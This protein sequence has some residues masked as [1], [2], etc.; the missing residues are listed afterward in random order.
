MNKQLERYSVIS[1]KNPR[2]ILLLR[3]KGCSWRNCRFCDYHLDYSLDQEA[4]AQLNKEVLSQVTG[5]FGVL[6]IINS[7][8]FVDLD[9]RTME[10]IKET[11][12]AKHISQIHF[13]SHWLHRQDIQA[14]R[15]FFQKDA[16]AV[17]MKIGVETFDRDFRETVMVKGIDT[18]RPEDIAE[19]FDECCLLF[20]LTGQILESMRNDISIGLRYFERVCVNIMVDNTTP[21]KA[22]PEVIAQFRDH[23]YADCLENQRIDVLMENTDF[24][25]GKEIEH[26]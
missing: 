11:C 6:E 15:D 2:E 5:D 4:N 3:G 26:E 20:G 7:G 21:I 16:I 14:L 8:S 19:Y 17:K 12:I 18:S 13:E 23:L 1:Q 22:D 24:G 25:V 10:L 9:A